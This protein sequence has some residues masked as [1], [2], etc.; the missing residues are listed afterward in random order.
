MKFD[1][2][3]YLGLLPLLA[4]AQVQPPVVEPEIQR[5]SENVVGIISKDPIQGASKELA[6][7]EDKVDE[8]FC[9]ADIENN[10]SCEA[11]AQSLMPEDKKKNGWRTLFEVKYQNIE[12][13]E[14]RSVASAN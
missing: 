13:K 14:R 4:H 2:W 6:E 7:L 1:R 11:F 5:T 10:P 12:D 8:D 9:P 3:L